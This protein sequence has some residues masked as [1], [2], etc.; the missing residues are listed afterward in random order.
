MELLR[1]W[2]PFP[3]PLNSC[4]KTLGYI[5]DADVIIG[6]AATVAVPFGDWSTPKVVWLSARPVVD[7]WVVNAAVVDP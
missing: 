4:R 1:Y 2:C 3:Y 5:P 7:P 6:A